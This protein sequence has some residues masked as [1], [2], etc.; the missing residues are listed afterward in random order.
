MLRA[1]SPIF[2]AGPHADALYEIRKGPGRRHARVHRQ[3]LV[4][5]LA[6][7]PLLENAIRHGI[8]KHREPNVITICARRSDEP[9]YF[10]ICNLAGALEDAPKDSLRRGLGLS[11]T[12]ARLAQLYGPEQSFEIRSLEPRGVIVVISIPIQRRTGRQPEIAEAVAQ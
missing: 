10:E 2:R 7:Q 5:S 4:P 3:S 12:Q 6:L 9:L 8:G 1:T 11:N